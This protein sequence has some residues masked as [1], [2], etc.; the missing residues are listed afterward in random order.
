MDDISPAAR[1]MT[2]A[3]LAEARGEAAR[4]RAELDARK[5]WGLWRRVR[6]R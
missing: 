3:E 2:C 6:G 4:L 1:R 5:H